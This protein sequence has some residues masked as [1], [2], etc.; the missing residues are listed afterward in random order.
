MRNW[1]DIRIGRVMYKE[2]FS[3]YD[4]NV[5]A[6]AFVDAWEAAGDENT[7]N[8]IACVILSQHGDMLVEF[9]DNDA[10]D[11]V[12]VERALDIAMDRLFD[13]Y[14]DQQQMLYGDLCTS[15]GNTLF[16]P[17]ENVDELVGAW[18]VGRFGKHVVVETVQDGD[19]LLFEFDGLRKSDYRK[20]AELFKIFLGVSDQ[21]FV[22]IDS[23]ECDFYF[24]SQFL[25][26][27]ISQYVLTKILKESKIGFFDA[28]ISTDDGVLFAELDKDCWF[29]LEYGKNV[30]LDDV[31][32]RAKAQAAAQSYSKESRYLSNER[33]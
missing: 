15:L 17:W 31:L 30:E 8:T 26:N 10:R 33:V 24:K 16:M 21:G 11:N 22:P 32:E 12:S 29:N 7:K 6:K 20:F 13:Y 27:Y 5:L 2:D 23:E 4:G 28:V 25:P 3:F 19:D 14:M 18:A 1:A 9:Y